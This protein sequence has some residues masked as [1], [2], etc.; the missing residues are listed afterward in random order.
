MS[1]VNIPKSNTDSH[2]RY[3]R[4]LLSVSYQGTLRT[5][6]ENIDEV[7]KACITPPEYPLKFIGYELGSQTDIKN[8]EYTING[9]HSLEK[10]EEL[11]EK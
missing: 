11:L 3:R 8:N 2:Y 1:I 4:P 10:L 9:K 6:L 7:A 5:K